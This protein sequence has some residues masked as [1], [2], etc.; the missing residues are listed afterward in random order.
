MK[1]YQIAAQ[2]Y[3]VRD[4][5]KDEKGVAESFAKVRSLGYETVQISG[6]GPIDEKVC[7]KLLDDHGLRCIATHESPKMLFEEP[8]KVVERLKKL[9][10]VHTAFPHPGP[11]P[12][13]TADDVKKLADSLAECGRILSENGIVFSYHNHHIEFKKVGGK[14]ILDT[15]LDTVPAEYLKMELDTYW[16]QFGGQEPSKWMKKLAGRMPLLHLKDYKVNEENAVKFAEI[17]NGNLDWADIIPSAEKG[18]TE[19][20]IVEQDVC[21]GDPFESLK[22]SYDFIAANFCD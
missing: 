15:L 3:T 22:Q 13:N 20:F 2:L 12:L 17:G 10:C 1:K 8:M 18:G 9:S 6:M 14:L 19:W 11:Y 21:D 5:I 7:K 16:A 4:F